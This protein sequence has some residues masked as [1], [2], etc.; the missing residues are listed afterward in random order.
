MDI[1]LNPK[2]PGKMVVH[3]GK[4]LSLTYKTSFSR[5]KKD[6][7]DKENLQRLSRKRVKP[8]AIGGRKGLPLTGKAEGEE[9]VYARS[10]RKWLLE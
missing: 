2:Y 4:L 8:Q 6:M 5:W 10:E 7:K 3:A 9:I 1:R